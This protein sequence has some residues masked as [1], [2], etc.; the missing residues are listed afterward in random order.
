MWSL[1]N[2]VKKFLLIRLTQRDNFGSRCDKGSI[3]GGGEER[4]THTD[5]PF[6][7]FHDSD[8]LPDI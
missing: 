4:E 6:S 5:R 8:C 7:P 3:E 2:N 1:E